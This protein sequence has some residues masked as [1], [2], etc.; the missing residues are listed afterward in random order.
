MRLGRAVCG[1]IL[2][3]ALAAGGGLVVWKRPA[4]EPP[5]EPVR[6][7]LHELPPE[8]EGERLSQYDELIRKYAARYDFD[9]RLIAAMIAVESRFDA[10]C[11]TADGGMGLMQLMPDTAEEMRCAKPFD[12]EE[13]IATGVKFLRSLCDRIPGNLTERDRLQFALAAYNGGY[14]HL[15][16]A[17]KLAKTLELSP[18]KWR[19]NVEESIQFLEHESYYKQ[20]RHG[21]CKAQVIIRHVE[22]VM[23]KFD[24]Y[25]E[26]FSATGPSARRIF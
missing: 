6:L 3:A 7:T 16:D 20:S 26:R 5:T 2:L 11:R 10:E 14:G 1:G 17:R 13:N 12:P 15:I 19:G 21:Y 9:W 8:E 18:D 22:R 25:S 4:A 24:E 23:K